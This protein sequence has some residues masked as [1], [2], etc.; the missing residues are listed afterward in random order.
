[1]TE[2]QPAAPRP[3]RDA[4]VRLRAERSDAARWT[5]AATEAGHPSLSSWLRAIADE[6]AACRCTGRDVAAAVAALRGDAGRI[7]NVLNQVAHRGHLG[8]LITPADLAPAL[9]DLTVLRAAAERALRG[10]RPP[11]TPR[12]P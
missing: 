6:A 3:R 12:A 11:R 4:V 5:A 1:M 8:G 7:G 2:Q 10:V 9:A